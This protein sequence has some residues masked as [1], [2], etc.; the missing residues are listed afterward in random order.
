MLY[1]TSVCQAPE[2]VITCARENLLTMQMNMPHIF[3]LTDEHCLS[4]QTYILFLKR[5][6]N[7]PA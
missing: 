7:I 2:S 3:P 4:W 6:K 5:K 1:Y